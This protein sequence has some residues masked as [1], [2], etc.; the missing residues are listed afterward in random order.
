L[1]SLRNKRLQV[2]HAKLPKRHWVELRVQWQVDGQSLCL[3][4][5]LSWNTRTKSF[6]YF[7]T[8]LA[9]KRYPLEVICRAYKWR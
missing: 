3:Q 1:P 4:L 8:N 6:C 5:I 2:I 7:L 9:P